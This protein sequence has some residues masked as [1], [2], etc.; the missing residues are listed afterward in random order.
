MRHLILDAIAAVAIGALVYVAAVAHA[1]ESSPTPI[2]DDVRATPTPRPIEPRVAVPN[3]AVAAPTPD[4]EPPEVVIVPG[5]VY[6]AGAPLVEAEVRAVLRLAGWSG[7]ALEQAVVVS[8][9]ESGIYEDGVRVWLPAIVGDGGLALGLFQI[10]GPDVGWGHRSIGAGP[11]ADGWWGY[12][13]VSMDD[14]A[15]AVVNAR[16]ARWAW[17][18][19]GWWPWTCARRRGWA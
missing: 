6:T 13:G 5:A 1:Q 15:N 8:F 16:L 12:F 14:Y 7:Y 10:H 2:V 18:E 3:V 17:E 11:A 9:C 19:S 4:P